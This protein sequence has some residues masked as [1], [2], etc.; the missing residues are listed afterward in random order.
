MSGQIRTNPDDS[1][2]LEIGGQAF[3]FFASVERVAN[4][5]KALDDASLPMDDPRRCLGFEAMLRMLERNDQSAIHLAL[6]HFLVEGNI[7]SD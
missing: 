5:E 1:V 4:L 3:R 7:I 2:T 6:S